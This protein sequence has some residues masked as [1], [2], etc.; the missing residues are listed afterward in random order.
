M[1]AGDLELGPDPLEEGGRPDVEVGFYFF[2]H[3]DRALDGL[4]VPPFLCPAVREERE[5]EA[6]ALFASRYFPSPPSSCYLPP[7]A[8]TY[9]VLSFQLPTLPFAPRI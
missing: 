4:E 9:P 3:H 5:V 7:C 6:Y 8:L 1:V 2:A